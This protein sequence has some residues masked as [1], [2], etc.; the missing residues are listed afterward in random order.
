[1]RWALGGYSVYIDDA[2]PR[3]VSWHAGVCSY[4][5]SRAGERRVAQ[6]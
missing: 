2:Q 3:R 5:V 1:M 6:G 4:E